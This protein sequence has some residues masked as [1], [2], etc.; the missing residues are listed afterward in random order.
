[1][2]AS[3]G[4]LKYVTAVFTVGTVALVYRLAHTVHTEGPLLSFRLLTRLGRQ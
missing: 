2:I 3:L 4:A 1:M